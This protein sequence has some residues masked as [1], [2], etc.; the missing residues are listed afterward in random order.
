MNINPSAAAAVAGT[1]RA[2]ARGGEA[3]NQATESTRQQSA[4][5]TPGGKPSDS[6]AVDAGDQ[7]GDR[8]GNGQQVLD[9]FERGDEEENEQQEDAAP[10]ANPASPDGSGENLD[11]QA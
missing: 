2:A 1:S 9:I 4:A 11:L 6:N 5:E 8:G 10:N 7:T 3:D